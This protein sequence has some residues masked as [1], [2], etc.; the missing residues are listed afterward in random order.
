M[1]TRHLG[2]WEHPEF[3]LPSF[4]AGLGCSGLRPSRPGQA[5]LH[6]EALSSQRWQLTVRPPDHSSFT[7]YLCR[8]FIKCKEVIIY[9]P[10]RERVKITEEKKKKAFGV[11]GGV[12]SALKFLHSFVVIA[13]ITSH[14]KILQNNI[15]VR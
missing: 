15:H 14:R 4:P 9:P 10:P 5:H 3:H 6:H 13:H 2:S 7:D 1:H 12:C 8:V 11:V